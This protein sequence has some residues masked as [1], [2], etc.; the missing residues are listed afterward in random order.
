[1]AVLLSELAPGAPLL[2]QH[3]CEAELLPE[4]ECGDLPYG[5]TKDD[6]AGCYRA[7]QGEAWS[8]RSVLPLF[9]G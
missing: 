7:R 1:M 5:H 8:R 9:L 4:T 6:A 2:W 3:R